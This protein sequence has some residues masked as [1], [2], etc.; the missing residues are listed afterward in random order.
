ME[1]NMLKLVKSIKFSCPRANKRL[2]A[3]GKTYRLR[4][5]QGQQSIVKENE[6]I[7]CVK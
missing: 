1:F 3:Q 6:K 4:N 2:T 7:L 5:G